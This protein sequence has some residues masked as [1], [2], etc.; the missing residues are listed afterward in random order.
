MTPC[1]VAVPKGSV[2]AGAEL[3]FEAWILTPETGGT[4]CLSQV[5]SVGW[6]DWRGQDK[7]RQVEQKGQ[8]A[9]GFKKTW[10]VGLGSEQEWRVLEAGSRSVAER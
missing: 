3:G 7:D 10:T 5:S 6:A 2:E 4:R 9:Q 8:L 1:R